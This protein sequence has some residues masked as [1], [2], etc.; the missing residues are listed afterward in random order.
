M[1]GRVHLL[2]A[3]L[4]VALV[5]V[6]CGSVRVPVDPDGTLD[7]VSGGVLR[8]G[9]SPHE[10]WTTVGTDEPGGIEAD[11]VRGWAS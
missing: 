3:L 10:P 11:L 1:A 8:V 2:A 6:G 7:R 4:A 9:V 5:L